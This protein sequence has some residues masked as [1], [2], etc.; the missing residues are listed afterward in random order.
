M[1]DDLRDLLKYSFPQSLR[2][3]A[4]YRES[5]VADDTLFIANLMA[6]DECD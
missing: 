1:L 6:F 5:L 3:A 4:L 2:T